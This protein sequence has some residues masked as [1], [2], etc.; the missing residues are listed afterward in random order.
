MG[1]SALITDNGCN[2]EDHSAAS[3]VKGMDRWGGKVGQ[4]ELDRH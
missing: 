3:G 4:T 2:R 1:V